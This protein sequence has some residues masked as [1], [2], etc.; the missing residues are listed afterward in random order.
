MINNTIIMIIVNLMDFYCK[1]YFHLE[2]TVKSYKN[3]NVS[4]A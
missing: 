1:Y 4:I 3:A 2:T